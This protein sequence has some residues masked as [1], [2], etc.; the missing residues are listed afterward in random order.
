MCSWLNLMGQY[1]KENIINEIYQIFVD[2]TFD[3][4]LLWDKCL[5]LSKISSID[6][7][8]AGFPDSIKNQ[9]LKKASIDTIIQKWNCEKLL[10]A[11]CVYDS[12]ISGILP[13]QRSY[14]HTNAERKKAIKENKRILELNPEERRI[15]YFSR[16]IV[17]HTN[18]YAIIEMSFAY[19]SGYYDDYVVSLFLLEKIN[20]KWIEVLEL[21]SFGKDPDD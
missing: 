10:K 16:P 4:Y 17:D 18:K 9:I 1:E 13:G 21:Y 12:T 6:F 3:E 5:P 2:S 7:N 8:K 20:G 15:Y 19:A 11:K 14:Y